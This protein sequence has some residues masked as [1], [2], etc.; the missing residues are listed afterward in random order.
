MSARH[1]QLILTEAGDASLPLLINGLEIVVF[2][3]EDGAT[4]VQID[5]TTDTGHVRVNVNDGAVLDALDL[6]DATTYLEA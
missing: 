3:A 4:V 5:T 6:D 2:V 1:D